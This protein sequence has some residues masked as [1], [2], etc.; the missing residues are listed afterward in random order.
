MSQL[1]DNFVSAVNAKSWEAAFLN[2]NGLNMYEML[3]A[4]AALP[5]QKM[6]ELSAQAAVAAGMVNMPRIQYAMEVVRT[7]KLPGVVP[8]DL[9]ETGQVEDARKF[10]AGG[11]GGAPLPKKV[12]LKICLFWA[13][14]AARESVSSPLIQGAVDLLHRNRD[15]LVLDVLP[16]RKTLD[17]DKDVS[18][19]EDWLE[20]RSQC[21]T[22]GLPMGRL[23]VVFCTF[24]RIACQRGSD[25]PNSPRG[26]TPDDSR[27]RRFVLINIKE[28]AADNVTLLHEIGHAA[29]IE[30]SDQAETDLKNF[31]S[32]GNGRVEIRENQVAKLAKAYFAVTAR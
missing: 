32:H 23:P 30:P 19:Q 13:K 29:F 7:R 25:C 22:A 15:R 8:G 20:V 11:G 5:A 6:A 12:L 1:R 17:W 26:S 28:H 3:R 24:Q 27:G 9:K 31:M 21:D 14:N 16:V 10:L 4:L 2:L 18:D